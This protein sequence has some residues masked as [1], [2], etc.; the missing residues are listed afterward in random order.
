MGLRALRSFFSNAPGR[1]AAGRRVCGVGPLPAPVLK[2][3]PARGRPEASPPP[4]PSCRRWSAAVWQGCVLGCAALLWWSPCGRFCR[5]AGVCGPWWFSLFSSRAVPLLSLCFLVLVWAG[6][7][8]FVPSLPV[9]SSCVAGLVAP[10]LRVSGECLPRVRPVWDL[11]SGDGRR[12][13]G[14]GRRHGVPG[15]LRRA[16]PSGGLAWV[17]RLFLCRLRPVPA[18]SA[19]H[20]LR[21]GLFAPAPVVWSCKL[22]SPPPCPAPSARACVGGPACFS[23]RGLWWFG[24][25][26]RLGCPV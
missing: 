10:A 11:V 26:C 23:L 4:F 16:G 15:G 25:S 24:F 18:R 17:V 3:R 1:A 8:R 13:F 14:L 7:F 19:V 2:G 6:F 5:G 22:L 12:P 20:R 21:Y 9:L